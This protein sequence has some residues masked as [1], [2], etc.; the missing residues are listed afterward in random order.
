M[1]AKCENPVCLSGLS[2]KKC[3]SMEKK[4]LGQLITQTT[5]QVLLSETAVRLCNAMRVFYERLPSH[6]VFLKCVKETE[7]F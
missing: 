7:I 6:G 5:A 1:S 3:F 4:Y 2:N